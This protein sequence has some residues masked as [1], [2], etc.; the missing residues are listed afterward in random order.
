MLATKSEVLRAGNVEK[1]SRTPALGSYKACYCLCPLPPTTYHPTTQRHVHSLLGTHVI[2]YGCRWWVVCTPCASSFA[3]T[4][5]LVL[6][7][8]PCCVLPLSVLSLCATK[9]GCMTP[10][11][12]A[13]N[14]VSS[15][16]L[17]VCRQLPRRQQWAIPQ[18]PNGFSSSM[19]ARHARYR[20]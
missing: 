17:R 8:V 14:G 9:L 16:N 15:D 7:P 1:S 4:T 20:V 6:L 18:N 2:G 12:G 13:A 3:T 19:V 5:P 10:N 11:G